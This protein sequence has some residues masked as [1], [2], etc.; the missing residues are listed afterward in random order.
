MFPRYAIT[1]VAIRAI[2]VLAN[3][4]SGALAQDTK[5]AAASPQVTP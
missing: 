1:V 4:T 5:P 3:W 2:G